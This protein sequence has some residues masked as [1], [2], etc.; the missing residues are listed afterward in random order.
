MNMAY[1]IKPN[2]SKPNTKGEFPLTV[3]LTIRNKQREIRTKIIAKKEDFTTYSN[4][5]VY[6]I[7]KHPNSTF[8]NREIKRLHVEI[9][10]IDF[11]NRFQSI[12]DFKDK[13]MRIM[14]GE[15]YINSKDIMT[16]DESIEEYLSK[17]SSR[18]NT[19]KGEKSKLNIFNNF[20]KENGIYYITDVDINI[21]LDYK[22]D[23]QD[24]G[25]SNSTINRYVRYVNT[26]FTYLYRRSIKEKWDY[27]VHSGSVI[28]PGT[29]NVIT[30]PVIFLKEEEISIIESSVVPKNLEMTKSLLLFQL[31]TGQRIN[32][33][34]NFKF[35]H[36]LD[37]YWVFNQS[38]TGKPM[39]LKFHEDLKNVLSKYSDENPINNIEP[40]SFNKN[41][42]KLLKV[43]KI[44]RLVT[45][46]K[47]SG[48]ELKRTNVPIHDI[49]SSHHLRKSFITYSLS[50][51]IP[52]NEVMEWSGHSSVNSM[53]PYISADNDKANETIGT[54]WVSR[55]KKLS[56]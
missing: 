41:L 38:K 31:Y 46:Y 32:D 27:D 44:N 5:R 37:G 39:R 15:N 36:I 45:L 10:K 54:E 18:P 12:N 16:I 20:C 17:S 13:V 19:L 42:K 2:Y 49:I 51:N 40:Q 4:G 52:I 43:L 34:M 56:S 22:Q 3:F 25:K 26:L 48:A 6:L 55:R 8:L 47:H 35:S 11:E 23:L 24:D 29:N 50:M 9:E 53:M 21:M 14:K 33:I 7:K 30:N 28:H 1:R